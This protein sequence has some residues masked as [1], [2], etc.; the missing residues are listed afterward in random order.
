MLPFCLKKHQETAVCFFNKDVS[1][2]YQYNIFTLITSYILYLEDSNCDLFVFCREYAPLNINTF[3]GYISATIAVLAYRLTESCLD[4][5]VSKATLFCSPKP[6]GRSLSSQTFSLSAPTLTSSM[7][8]PKTCQEG[9]WVTAEL[10][11]MEQFH[12]L[13]LWNVDKLLVFAEL[14]SLYPGGGGTV[15]ARCLLCCTIIICVI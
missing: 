9:R 5:G 3:D 12:V 7:K 14:M 8:M 11:D 10:A 15:A 6:S 13:S 4:L 1:V 2:Q